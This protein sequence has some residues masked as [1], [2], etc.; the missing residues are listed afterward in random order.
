VKRGLILKI[1][2]DGGVN[3]DF[4]VCGAVVNKHMPA[5]FGAPFAVMAL[6]FCIAAEMI[7]TLSDPEIFR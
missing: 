3:I 2:Q 6:N 5:T 4:S 1:L 7:L